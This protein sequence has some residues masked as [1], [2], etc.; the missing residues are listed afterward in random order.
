MSLYDKL[1]NIDPQK[2]HYYGTM[3]INI[4]QN[5]THESAY[6]YITNYFLY[7]RKGNVF[8]IGFNDKYK[9]EGKHEHTVVLYYLG[10][11]FSDLLQNNLVAHIRKFLQTNEWYDFRYTWFI[12]CLYHDTAAVIEK[13]D[14]TRGCPSNL[15][16][17]LGKYNVE[18]NVY[19]HNWCNPYAK[20]YTYAESLVRNYFKYRVEYC[21]S[22]DHG[23]IAGYLLYD[24]L[25]KNYNNA[26]KECSKSNLVAE[27]CYSDFL[28]RGLHWRLEHIAHFAIIADAIIAHNIWLN[29]NAKLY[30]Q[31]GLDQ[32]IIT[33]SN[34][35]TIV[36]NPL[37]FFLDLLDTIE[38]VKHFGYPNCLKG[39]NI[40]SNNICLDINAK[41]NMIDTKKAIEW[42]EKIERM[43]DWLSIE[44]E[45]YSPFNTKVSIKQVL[46]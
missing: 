13:E 40:D 18:Y 14:W 31:F 2:V 25:V 8:D 22:I 5:L 20:P 41:T 32:L 10:C 30:K 46:P 9:S 3:S 44:V 33:P 37:I 34:K 24:R 38:P 11:L 1:E 23:I 28:Y 45:D 26:W 35:L 21:H 15:E 27:Y 12:T 43:Q 7:G 6:D 19:E 4:I 16:F 39:I 36:D 17:Y 42:I 29:N